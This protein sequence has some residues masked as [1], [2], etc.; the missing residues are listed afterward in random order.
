[1]K[2][3]LPP[4]LLALVCAGFPAAAQTIVYWDPLSTGTANGGGPSVTNWNTTS[5]QWFDGVSDVVW[6]NSG[7]YRAVF[8]GP[9]GG[10]VQIIS[11]LVIVADSLVFNTAGYNITG[12]GTRRVTLTSGLIEANA[13][14]T[15]TT[16]ITNPAGAPVVGIIKT[17]AGKLTLA[18]ANNTFLGGLYV[19]NG[20]VAMSDKN[21]IGGPAQAIT[22]NGGG[23]ELTGNQ[24]V[25]GR[26]LFLGDSGGTI[27][28]PGAADLW[29]FNDLRGTNGILTKNGPGTL[30][31]PGPGTNGASRVGATI[32]N[33]GVLR[34][35]T[36]EASGL[37]TGPVTVN[38]DGTL[39][40]IGIVGGE[41]TVLGTLSPGASPGTLTLLNNLILASTAQ[42]NFDLDTAGVV[43]GGVNDW[44]DIAGDLTLDGTL[45]IT[46]LANF[47]AGTYQ[48]MAYGGNLQDNGLTLGT[49]SGTANNAYQYDIQAGGG[50]VNLVVSLVPEPGSW[51]LM[52][53]ALGLGWLAQHRRG[54]LRPAPARAQGSCAKPT[55]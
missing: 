36:T 8:G 12:G 44:V 38:A 27:H 49:L 19:L 6:N 14:A 21:Q 20:A 42:L 24:S 22:L 2:K 43:G 39:A 53:L 33:Q 18:A 40:G 54:R 9:S 46:G 3:S 25:S 16:A 10:T 11:G 30:V 34:A 17:G 47:G 7:T 41:V 37:G 26:T 31:L 23:L 4:V 28:L 35:D 15:I 51:A 45:N 5:P 52:L 29:S 55:P 13:D 50:Q 48:L 32:I 1:M